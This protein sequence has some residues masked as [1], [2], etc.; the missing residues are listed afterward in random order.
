LLLLSLLTS[1]GGEEKGELSDA[2]SSDKGAGDFMVPQML[3]V[4][5]RWP[6]FGCRLLMLAVS[7]SRA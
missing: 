7:N 4:H 5:H 1:H 6:E 2:F 3:G